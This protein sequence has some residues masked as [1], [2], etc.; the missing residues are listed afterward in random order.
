M[1][2]DWILNDIKFIHY[3]R[4]TGETLNNHYLMVGYQIGWW[5]K[6]LLAVIRKWLKITKHPF[7]TVSLGSQ[8]YNI[9]T[10]VSTIADTPAPKSPENS[11][12]FSPFFRITMRFTWSFWCRFLELGTSEMLWSIRQCHTW[13]SLKNNNLLQPIGPQLCSKITSWELANPQSNMILR[14]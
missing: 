6:P 2:V 4:N 3:L 12:F 13:P 10:Y 14:I 11:I 5:T 1:I 8:V 9:H 7:Q